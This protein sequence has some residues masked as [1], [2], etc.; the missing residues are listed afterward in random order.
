MALS[1]PIL[2]NAEKTVADGES[3][4]VGALVTSVI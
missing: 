4:G 1:S 3:T 2:R